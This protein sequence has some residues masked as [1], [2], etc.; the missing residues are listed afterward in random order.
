[1]GFGL[2]KSPLVRAGLL[3]LSLSLLAG[4]AG[5]PSQ[6]SATPPLPD[7]SLTQA[8][9][10]GLQTLPELV[11]YVGYLAELQPFQRQAECE[12]LQ[13]F[14]AVAPGPAVQLHLAFAL[15]LA[16]DCGGNELQQA[17]DLFK[18][19]LTQ[20]QDLQT[21]R[22]LTYH[23]ALA[24]HRYGVDRYHEELARKLEQQWKQANQNLNHR[25]QAC[26]EALRDAQSKL[27]ALKAIEQ[28]LN[29][30]ETP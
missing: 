20:V 7:Y 9:A 19:G 4:C 18:A 14:N 2:N 17:I 23:A 30:T 24:Q 3:S 12:W 11:S 5:Q 28:S 25:L 15:L 1:M 10:Y 27:E 29:P 26:S 22:F 16:P 8:P 6:P 21:R 13:R